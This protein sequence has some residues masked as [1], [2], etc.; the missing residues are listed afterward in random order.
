[1]ATGAVVMGKIPKISS[2]S[3]IGVMEYL[4]QKPT[5]AAAEAVRNLRTSIQMSNIDNPPKVIV[6]TSS[7]PGEGKTTQAIALANNFAAMNKRVLL[8][9]GDIR[10]N[11]LKAYFKLEHKGGLVSVI[12]GERKLEE[13]IVR[14]EN[15]D[16]D[17]LMGGVLRGNAADLF[18]SERFADLVKEFRSQYDY[19]IID[20]PPVLLVP[21][22][23]IIGQVADAIIYAVK[24]DKTHKTQV[25]EGQRE[26]TSVGLKV[27]GFVL[28]Q[29][30]VKGM[31]KY[32]YGGEYGAYAGY[33]KGYYQN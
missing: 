8:I 20:T 24:W 27:T 21:D 33:G 16:F 9:E 25:Q 3:R 7:L 28:S 18:S 11:V 31:K 10:R 4:R 13:V 22:A 17:I 15:Y 1:M 2:R 30:N 32:G 26:F 14:A 6:S 29:I 5:S 19:I 23:R 12:M